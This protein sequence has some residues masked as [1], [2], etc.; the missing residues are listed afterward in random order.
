MVLRVNGNI[1]RSNV[2]LGVH[3]SVYISGI[4]TGFNSQIIYKHLKLKTLLLF[5]L[6]L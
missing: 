4:M 5:T 3:L 2:L 6:T 1:H